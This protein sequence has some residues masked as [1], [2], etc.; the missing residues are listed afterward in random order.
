MKKTNSS[1]NTSAPLPESLADVVVE[2]SEGIID[3]QLADGVLKEIPVLSSIYG[4]LKAGRDIRNTL[5]LRKIAR[6]INEVAATTAEERAGFTNQ[7]ESEEDLLRLGETIALLLDRTDD[8]EKPKNIG[9]LFVAA[10]KNQV[11]LKKYL[12][13]AQLLIT[14]TFK[15]YCF[16][17]DSKM[18]LKRMTF[19]QLL[20]R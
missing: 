6:F 9:R 11:P 18:D 5:F 2:A 16:Y 7:F 12:G 14:V 1:I 8:T 10:V 4:A 15:T 3:S 17:L 20:N 13:R 19:D